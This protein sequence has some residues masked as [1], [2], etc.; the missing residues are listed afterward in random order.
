MLYQLLRNKINNE[1]EKKM[2]SND[3]FTK[4]LSRTLKIIILQS[5]NLI[6]NISEK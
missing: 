2:N 1:I 5:E 6:L 3:K 4:S